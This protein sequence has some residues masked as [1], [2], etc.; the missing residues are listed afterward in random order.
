[1]LSNGLPSDKK[2]NIIKGKIL[3]IIPSEFGK[4]VIIDAG[5]LFYA[6]ALASEMENL[7][8]REGNEVW[9]SF[10]GKDIVVINGN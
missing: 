7:R 3:E 5:E 9:M 1:M 4:E 6:N 2:L 8:L 10:S